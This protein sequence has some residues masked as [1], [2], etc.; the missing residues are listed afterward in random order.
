M[1]VPGLAWALTR[2]LYWSLR[3]EVRGQE[4][5][6]ADLHADRP[7]IITLWHSRALMMP[8]FYQWLGGGPIVIMASQS[9]D[10]VL[11]ARMLAHYGCRAAY[12][13]STHGG[14]E[15]LAEMISLGKKGWR[16]SLTPDGP[17]GP[18]EEVKPGAVKIASATGAP[19][20]PVT[21]F[22][23]R[24]VRFKSW[25]RFILPYPFARAIFIVGKAIRVPADADNGLLE[26]RR[27]ELEQEMRLIT[28][29]A[30]SYFESA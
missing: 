10:G 16:I 8:P 12:G 26:D 23:D 5:L 11:T 24:H 19:I 18:A 17:L 4:S 13:S 7:L 28:A 27:Q 25:D 6:Q 3:V 2:V 9:F 29:E 22:A 21:Y 30:E 15:G 20:Y 14:K 1:L